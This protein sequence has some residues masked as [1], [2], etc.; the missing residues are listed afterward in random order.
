MAVEKV[1]FTLPEELVRRLEKV[2]AGKRSTLVKRAVE[3]ELDREAAVAR[4]KKMSRSAIWK[5]K[6]HP[7][8]RTPNDFSGYRPL[9]SR[10]TG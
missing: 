4:F 10:L 8:L 2:P 3:K 1:T 5:E 9:K 7:D 6:H